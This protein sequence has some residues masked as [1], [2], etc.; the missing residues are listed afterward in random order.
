M[1]HNENGKQ[2]MY[3]LYPPAHPSPSP[4]PPHP[5]HFNPIMMD[6]YILYNILNTAKH[7]HTKYSFND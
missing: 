3:L 4:P 5:H 1:K 6:V 2:N 7:E